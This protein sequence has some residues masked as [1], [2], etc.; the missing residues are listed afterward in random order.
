MEMSGT[1]QIMAS[2]A[3]VW[4]ALNDPV[5]LRKCIPGCESLEKIDDAN[6]KGVVALRM[7]PMALKFAGDVALS[8]LNPPNSYRL[9][10]SGKAGVAGFASGFADV[11]LA[12]KDGGTELT[13]KVESTVGGRMAQL[14]SRLID[15]TAA[16]LAG[17]FFDKFAS[18]VGPAPVAAI[19]AAAAGGKDGA[20]S[21]ATAAVA[22]SPA[23]AVT[24]ANRSGMPAW[25][26]ALAAIALVAALVYILKGLH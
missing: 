3:D 16:Q 1:R 9:S 21:G 6:L 23:R 8:N 11:V 19:A 24:A 4:R 10:G 20:A 12:P 2:Q 14:G 15:A 26:W 25:M 18:E 17:E 5:V 7:G 22:K 13:Y